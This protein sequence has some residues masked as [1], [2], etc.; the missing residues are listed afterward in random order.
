[1]PKLLTATRILERTMPATTRRLL[2]YGAIALAYLASVLLGAGTF[3]G[4][5]SFAKNPSLWGQ[6]GAIF[7]L[8]ACI[9]AIR[10]TRAVLFYRV[11]LIH[12][13][14]MVKRLTDQELPSG[15][16]QLK[17][18]DA[19]VFGLFPSAQASFSCYLQTRQFVLESF[20]YFPPGNRI[21]QFLPKPLA[22]WLQRGLSASL[23]GKPGA[24]ALLALACKAGRLGDVRRGAVVW[25]ERYR[26]ILPHALLAG[27]FLYGL[28]LV[29][30]W[31]LLK[32]VAWVDAALP[33]DLGVWQY[34]FALILTYWIKAAF[35]D[36]IVTAAMT[37][38]LLELEKE[39]QVSDQTT[40]AWSA[41]LPSLA[42]LLCA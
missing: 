8:S 17:I 37:I 9:Y 35:L 23:F 25:C 3:Y 36:P 4:L 1:M 24:E 29:A 32:P 5:A 42:R 34:V 22:G 10:Q 38:T 16:E 19:F 40:Q 7:G 26:E 41:K 2:V 21:V 27:A 31:L 20:G 33:T 13:S 39:T 12:L 28:A 11:E 6:L 15:K 14:A 18:L 30:F